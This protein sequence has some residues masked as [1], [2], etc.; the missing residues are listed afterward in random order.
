MSHPTR[1]AWIEIFQPVGRFAD[2]LSHPTRGAWIEIVEMMY[3]SEREYS[4]TLP[5]VRG[6]K[7]S[8]ELIGLVPIRRTLPGVRGLKY[9]ILCAG[10]I[11]MKSHPTRGAWIE[12]ES[13]TRPLMGI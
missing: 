6:L 10:Y 9:R 5:G 12:M 11:D 3:K 1:G 4:R 2:D 8:W 13:T 7:S